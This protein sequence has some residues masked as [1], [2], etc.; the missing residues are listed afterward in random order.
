LPPVHGEPDGF[1]PCVQALFVQPAVE[2]SPAAT[3]AIMLIICPSELH[4]ASEL[5][6]HIFAPG[7]QP[8]Q[9]LS[10]WLQPLPSQL[11]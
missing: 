2:H 10:D 11:V 1:F 6:L 7:M 4:V 5:P 3:H 8:L 9:L